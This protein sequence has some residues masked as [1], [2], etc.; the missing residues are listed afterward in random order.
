MGNKDKLE[1]NRTE[2][3][4]HQLS[5][6]WQ[7]TQ[8]R[9][10]ILLNSIFD[11]NWETPFQYPLPYFTILN[12]H[13]EFSI[14]TYGGIDY[15]FGNFK[16]RSATNKK[17]TK[18]LK[19]SHETIYCEKNKFVELLPYPVVTTIQYPQY[20]YD[21]YGN[22]DDN[23]LSKMDSP[24]LCIN[25]KHIHYLLENNLIHSDNIN[26]TII[27][28]YKNKTSKKYVECRDFIISKMEDYCNIDE[29]KALDEIP[30]ARAL[31]YPNEPEID[32]LQK[33]KASKKAKGK[34]GRPKD[35][36]LPAKKD[37]LRKDYNTLKNKK[38]F[39]AEKALKILSEKYKWAIG[40]VI[41]YLK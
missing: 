16:E 18:L 23:G 20:I 37:S 12:F 5:I 41:S 38:G 2:H 7:D 27:N 8:I 33:T 32:K 25:S 29:V 31:L 3:E 35:P 21:T 6:V 9:L 26:K 10:Y 4:I 30:K 36:K 17:I 24:I 15:P 22:N 28:L 14:F 39:R 1:L 34:G 40:T 13:N 19:D 11:N